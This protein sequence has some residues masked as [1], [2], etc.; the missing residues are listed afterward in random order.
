MNVIALDIGGTK[1][2]G[3]VITAEG[4][5]LHIKEQPTEALKGA[6][7]ILNSTFRVIDDLINEKNIK[8]IGI[9]SA[10][11][12]NVEEGSVFYATPNLPGWTGLHLRDIFQNKY[13]V[14]VVVDNDVNAAAIGE[15]WLG[16]ARELDSY[17]CITLGTGVGGA[18]VV[19]KK[20]WRGSQWSGAE[21]G[22]MILK[23]GGRPC[24][25]GLS[26]C[27]EQ[28]VSGTAI[29][30]RYNELSGK[31][32]KSAAEV[33]NLVGQKDPNAI[34]VIQEFKRDIID[35]LLSLNNIFDPRGYVIGGGI[36]GARD[37]WWDDVVNGVNNYKP[38]TV[39]PAELGNRAG[40][41]GAARLI[42]D[43]MVV[44]D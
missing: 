23:A 14:P 3:A 16:A 11:R 17:V 4:E 20:V 7:H 41:V 39:L 36:L 2:S 38:T 25:C 10:G 33:F 12:I 5:M 30:S 9:A 40:L 18:F 21:L 27:V 13:N 43:L 44:G 29:Y 35:V 24:N 37:Y 28:Y 6:E 31:K 19:N 22:H 15:G 32:V 8:G 26:G 34:Q 42:L 1:I